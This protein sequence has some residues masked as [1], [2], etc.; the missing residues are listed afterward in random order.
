MR[1]ASPVRPRLVPLALGL[2]AASLA[3]GASARGQGAWLELEAPAAPVSE[4]ALSLIEVRGHA[5][6]RAA[7]GH[8]LVLALDLSDSTT[9]TSGLDLDG[10]GESGRTSPEILEALRRQPGIDAVLVRSLAELDLEESVL[11]AELAAARALIQR[12]DPRVFR[13]GIVAFSDRARQVAPLGARPEALERALDQ[14]G[15]DFWRDLRGTNFADAIHAALAM[16]APPSEGEAAEGPDRESAARRRPEPARERSIV[17]LSDG[18]PTLPPHGDRPRQ[19]SIE[20]AQ[21]AALAGARIYAFALGREADPALDVYRALASTTGGGFDRLER[22]GDAI[23]RIRRID[24]VGLAKLAVDNLSTGEAARALRTF[25]DGSFDSFV[26][27]QEGTNRLR[28]RVE[29]TD[30]SAS[31]AELAVTRRAGGEVTDAARV[32]QA[33]LLAEL[34][35]RTREMQLWAEVE[36][37][38]ARQLR[39]LELHAG[40]PEVSGAR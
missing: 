21:D 26:S 20:A 40:E 39:E 19:F 38:R 15:R 17:L 13:V 16:L 27:L 28:V 8:D 10:D 3:A 5:G 37:G 33:A 7:R 9:A 25:P 34:R 22:P 35:R 31:S 30:G 4:T 11:F 12:L 18:A 1:H 14:L 23:A 36:Q 6:A 32:Q 24:F 29:L 2:A